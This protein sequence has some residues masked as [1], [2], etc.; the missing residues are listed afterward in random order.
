MSFSKNDFFSIIFDNDCSYDSNDEDISSDEEMTCFVER[1]APDLEN[2]EKM[3]KNLFVDCFFS[4]TVR[5]TNNSGN[6]LNQ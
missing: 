4:K 2:L 6:H 3:C 1:I 5:K